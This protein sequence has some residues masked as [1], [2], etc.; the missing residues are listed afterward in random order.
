MGAAKGKRGNSGF[1]FYDY[2]LQK[3][4]LE[5][6]LL[7]EP[8]KLFN[9]KNINRDPVNPRHSPFKVKRDNKYSEVVEAN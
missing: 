2:A 1:L 9:R 6:Y 8:E 7:Y 5:V 3:F 4:F